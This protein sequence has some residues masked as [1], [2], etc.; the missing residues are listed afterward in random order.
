MEYCYV[1]NDDVLLHIHVQPG[2]KTTQWAGLYGDAIKIRLSAP[3]V[4]GKA[5]DALCS[6]LA[7]AFG[8]AARDVR[9]IRGQTSRQKTALIDK[10]ANRLPDIKLQLQKYL[11]GK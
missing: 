10:A 3:P 5:N 4:D 7:Q 1:K 9:V 6:F 8:Y 2:A 11:S